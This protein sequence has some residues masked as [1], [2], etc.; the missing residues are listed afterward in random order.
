[1]KAKILL[2]S[3]NLLG[4]G[5]ERMLSRLSLAL[6][7]KYD[8]DVVLFDATKIAYPYGGKL[9]DL[10]CGTRVGLLQNYWAIVKRIWRC[11]RLLKK[12]D[13]KAVFLFT[14]SSNKILNFCKTDAKVFYSCRGYAYLHENYNNYHRLLAPNRAILF[15]SYAL[16]AD[17]LMHYPDDISQTMVAYNFYDVAAIHQKKTEPLTGA[18]A[19]FFDGHP[20]IVSVGRFSSQ[21]GQWNLLKAFEILKQSNPTVRLVFVGS[22]GSLEKSIQQMATQSRYVKDILF[23]GFSSNPY[24]YLAKA[25]VFVLPSVSEGFPNAMVEAMICGAP[26]VATDCMTGPREIL[27]GRC[28]P[29]M[30]LETSCTTDCGILVPTMPE[31]PDF[32]YS[33]LSSSHRI[34]A[35]AILQILTDSALQ[36]RMAAALAEKV[37]QFDESVLLPQYVD[38]IENEGN[39]D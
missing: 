22:R 10:A 4:G 28:V 35:E 29:D 33:N 1:M 26:V 15:N 5:S 6:Q 16:Q 37:T 25:A 39:A 13:Y 31:T 32:D 8:V 30:Q 2:I 20:V 18:D 27:C 19:V 36:Q 21:K 9:L 14:G 11:R 7:D 3:P 12:G 24:K 23:V 17:Y 38:L 34:M